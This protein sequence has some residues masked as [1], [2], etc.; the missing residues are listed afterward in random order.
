V[1]NPRIDPSNRI[2]DIGTVD[3]DLITDK[4]ILRDVLFDPFSESTLFL[5]SPST[6]PHFPYLKWGFFHGPC[7]RESREEEDEESHQKAHGSIIRRLAES[8]QQ[9]E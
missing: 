2:G 9:G 1:G 4:K 8:C 7:E 6:V 3:G 5:N